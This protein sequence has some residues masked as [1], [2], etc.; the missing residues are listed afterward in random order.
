MGR[1]EM[2]PMVSLCFA[3]RGDETRGFLFVRAGCGGRA[4]H[5]QPRA[6]PGKAINI[7]KAGMLPGCG[8]C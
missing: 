3:S 7:Q 2:A 4:D 6:V 8:G 5:S 1:R